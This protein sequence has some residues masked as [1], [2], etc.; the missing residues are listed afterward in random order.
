MELVPKDFKKEINL[1]IGRIREKLKDEGSDAILI[2]SNANIYYSTGRFFRG[3]VYIPLKNDPLWFV[4]KPRLF[5]SEENI[6]NIRKP[7]DIPAI[8][9]GQEYSLP[10]TIALEE[11]DLSYSDIMRLKALFPLAELKNGSS[12]MKKARMVKTA[13]E[14]A[15][16]KEDGRH[17]VKVYGEIKDCYQPGMSDL[18][19]QIE[20]E[21]R[22]RLEGSLG[23]SRVSGNLM[24]INLGSVISGDN[25]DNP[26]PYEFTMGGAGVN[27]ALPVGANNSPILKGQTV[28]IDMNGAFNGYQT[29]VTRVWSLGN[30]P[31]LAQSAHNCSIRILRELEKKAVPGIPVSKLYEIACEIVSKENLDKYFMGHK[32]QVSFIGHGVGI[33]L[34]EL[35]VINAKSKDILE[36]NMTL[37]IEPKFVIPEVGAVGV[38]NTYVVTSNGLLN[39]TPF[40]EEIQ[41]F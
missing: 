17:H 22:L 31:P 19:L 30:I 18:R 24:E 33:E 4:I 3:Y 6:F 34:N 39:I 11:S 32:S 1:R 16:M 26:A 12:V 38:E 14:L 28:M 40:P 23:V 13:W 41:N 21:K 20:I 2:G 8:L 29:D 7:E 37:A 36:E 35:P 10:D 27:S 9:K 25:A 5:E 15:E